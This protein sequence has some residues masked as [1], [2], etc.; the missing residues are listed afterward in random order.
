[1]V[2][3]HNKSVNFFNGIGHFIEILTESINLLIE[4]AILLIEINNLRVKL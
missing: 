2:V 1:M 4:L 3:C